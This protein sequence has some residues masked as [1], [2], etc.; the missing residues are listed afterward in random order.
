MLNYGG[1][2]RSILEEAGAGLGCP[3]G[4]VEAFAEAARNLAHDADLRRTMGEAARILA[5]TRFDRDA[6]ASQA[7]DILAH[8][9]KKKRIR[10]SV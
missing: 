2:Q 8:C 4:N 3:Q 9:G 6:L 1:W 5:L 7:L 10:W